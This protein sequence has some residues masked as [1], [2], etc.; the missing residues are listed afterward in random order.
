M[1]ATFI[2]NSVS[3]ALKLSTRNILIDSGTTKL[4]MPSKDIE[5]VRSSLQE[6]YSISCDL[7]PG[8]HQQYND[9]YIGATQ[10]P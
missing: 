9:S 5:I 6:K 4:T 8:N 10:S 2:G 3:D 7:V 1:S